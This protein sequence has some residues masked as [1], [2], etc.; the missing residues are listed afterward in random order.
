MTASI[1]FVI[2]YSNTV[3]KKYEYTAKSQQTTNE[4]I[5]TSMI[6]RDN[7]EDNNEKTI[8]IHEYS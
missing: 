1:C 8:D 7:N 3:R 2:P 6:M 4:L 5:M